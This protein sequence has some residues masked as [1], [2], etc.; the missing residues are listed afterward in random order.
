MKV[1]DNVMKKEQLDIYC[2]V[3]GEAVCS[4]SHLRECFGKQEEINCS[5]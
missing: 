4:K 2:H 3:N 1:Q 5:T